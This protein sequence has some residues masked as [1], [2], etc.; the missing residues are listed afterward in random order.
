MRSGL[1]AGTGLLRG[2]AR[3]SAAVCRGV[4]VH[5]PAPVTRCR[6]SG[7]LQARTGCKHPGCGKC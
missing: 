3:P 1:R 4:R 7:I 6:L 5:R 2:S